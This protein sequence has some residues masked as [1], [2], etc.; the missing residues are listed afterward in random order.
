MERRAG[1]LLESERERSLR[2]RL[3]ARDERAL[4][5]LVEVATP[6]LL[7]VARAMLHDEDE[8]EEVVTEAF[9][10]LWEHVAPVT[11]DESGLVPYLL[12]VTR[13]RAIDRLRARQRHG[14][15]LSVVA[16]AAA[17][18]VP[19]VEPDE[20]GTPGWRVHQ[21]VHAAL[22]DLPADQ[23]AV[24]DLA[25]FQGKTQAEVADELGI[26]IGTVKS[27]LHRAFGRLRDLL[28][29]LEDWVA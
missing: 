8:A 19:P 28:A 29:G 27:R 18:S 21:Q 6:W 5:E 26:P 24:V 22:D 25:Y 13:H 16:G 15:S 1:R 14:R 4:A 10:S 2:E 9:R 20:A 11:D 23:R 3:V 12:R 17:R 7:N